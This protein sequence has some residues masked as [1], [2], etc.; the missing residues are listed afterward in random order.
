M[1]L[2]R[3][4]TRAMLQ[5]PGRTILTL[6]SIVIGVAAAVAIDLGTATTR[7][8][9]QK[10][11]ATV[12]GKATLEVTAAGGVAFDEK[13]LDTVAK[14]P[15]VVAA[16]PVVEKPTSLILG[17]KQIRLQ[18][19]GI[20]PDL[21]RAVRDY[22]IVAG[23]QLGKG[24]E[25]VLDEEFARLLDVKVGDEVGV[26]TNKFKKPFVVVG[27][28]KPRGGEVLRQ[29]SMAFMPIERAQ[30]YF[31][32]RGKTNR[33]DKIQIVTGSDE[34]QIEKVRAA[35]AAQMP[36]P[37]A[38]QLD[39]EPLMSVY[40]PS[41]GSSLME[42]TLKSSEIGLLMASLFSLLLAAFIILNT[43]LMNVG[44]RRRHLAIMRA[45]G[46]TRWQLTR[47]LIGES[48]LLGTVGTALG[49]A[50]GLGAAWVSNRVL[51]R[52]LDVTLATVDEVLSPKPF[53][54]GA[55]F[56]LGMSLIGVLIPA[57]R[58]GKISPLEGMSRVA[59]GDLRNWSWSFFW[60]GSIM[61]LV[62]AVLIYAGMMGWLPISA[63]M[64]G[65]L[66]FLAGI[67]A[68]QTVLLKP[69]ASLIASLFRPFRPV[70]AGLALKQILRHN[71]RSALTVGVLFIAGATGVSMANS[72]MDNVQD[73]HD[74]MKAAVIG[75]FFVRALM[76]DMATGTAPDLPD[77]MREEL[78]NVNHVK[79]L[80]GVAYIEAK[81]LHRP[82]SAQ[83]A[84]GDGGPSMAAA[85]PEEIKAICI[86]R[87]FADPDALPFDLIVGDARQLRNQLSA[88]EVVLGS[89]LAQRLKRNMGD[90]IDLET[91]D[92]VQPVKIAAVTNE[93]MVGGM[94][95]HMHRDWAIKR[96]GIEGYDAFIIRVDSPASLAAVKPQLEA[97]CK[98][99][100]VIL[101]S[102]A[103]ISLNVSRIVGGIQWSLWLLVY[104][105]FVVAAFGVVN[106]LTM[107]VLEQT[108]ELGLLRIVAMT[109][110]QVRRTIVTQ[111]LII[112][113]VGLPPGIFLGVLNAY[114]MNLGMMSSFGHPIEFHIHPELLVITMVGSLLIILIAAIIPAYRATRIDVVE[115]LHYE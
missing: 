10:M 11:F 72:I 58:I 97:I 18:I 53:V 17:E 55:I 44:E 73:V 64:Y 52:S 94:A 114:V 57:I 33:Y 50:V 5:R 32:P 20:K 6:L 59:A 109:K 69:Q 105:G 19:M 22:E 35:L 31:Y 79:T 110:A 86:A 101:K 54:L 29:A 85:E 30:Y 41:G 51:T 91:K 108:R 66:V 61:M 80:D 40:R 42:H 27:L 92:G 34:A 46:A 89:V 3:Y 84:A 37:K 71:T 104:L 74:W 43:L 15:G 36:L 102:Y 67:V 14:T 7:E 115:A 4:T 75:D 68:L 83:A 112:G 90:T 1:S 93:Y 107:N 24:D 8:S 49:I 63:P 13:I 45:I 48:L 82:D 16:A 106:T 9:Y 2:R 21:D 76:P 25:L 39:S 88:G 47:A 99:H 70:E 23:R 95:I 38:D 103:E 56:G 113:G 78:Q 12:T 77:G 26:R 60:L 96:L 28:Q 87:E 62:G 100:D 98:R 81:V 111:A 65:G